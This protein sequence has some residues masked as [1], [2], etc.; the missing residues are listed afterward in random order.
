MRLTKL[1]HA[2]VRL[3]KDGS[4]LVIDPGTFSDAGSALTGAGAVLITHEHADHLD[5]D[6][7]RAAMSGD[8]GLHMWTNA[9]VA[10]QFA[11]LLGAEHIGVECNEDTSWQYQPEQTTSALICHHPRAKY[12][13]AR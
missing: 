4:V 2:C 1:G 3:E 7:V 10:S 6:Q 5:A 9:G 8:P 11:E 13:V 12:F